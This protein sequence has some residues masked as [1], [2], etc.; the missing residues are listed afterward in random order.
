[1]DGIPDIHVK[2]SENN[3]TSFSNNNRRKNKILPALEYEEKDVDFIKIH[4]KML[5][6]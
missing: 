6:K 5:M 1:L 2:T 3:T 4:E